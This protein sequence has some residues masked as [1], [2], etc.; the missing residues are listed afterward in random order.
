MIR[1]RPTRAASL[2]QGGASAVP[3]GRGREAQEGHTVAATVAVLGPGGVGGLLAGL[4]ARAGRRVV[5]LAGDDTAGA[6]RKDGITVHSAA[7]GDFTTPVEADTVLRETPDVV[8]V[9]VK[10]TALASALERVPPALVGPGT[11]IVPLL[12]GVEHMDVLR[13]RYPDA[14]VVGATIRVESTRTAPGVIEHGTPFT[15]LR[16]ACATPEPAALT[17]LAESLR[18]AGAE[19]VVGG[20]EKAALWDK[21]AVLAPFALLTTYFGTPVGE[22]RTTH[23]QRMLGVIE[24]V[25]AVARAAGATVTT[26]AVVTFFDTVP[27]TMKSSMQRDVEAARATELDAIGGAVLR[28]AERH[29]VPVPDTTAL[30]DRLRGHG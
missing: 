3:D 29:G 8:L 13:E 15:A 24:E 16:L 22:V 1:Q 25:T 9:T 17:Q 27:E 4:L 23:R 2:W 11:V 21:L 26:D 20:D 30:V 5:C 19:V 7:H 28:A 6:L 10:Q 14:H 12:N 18:G